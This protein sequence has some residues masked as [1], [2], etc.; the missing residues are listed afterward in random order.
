LLVQ[1]AGGGD[2]DAAG[3]GAD[4]VE[5]DLGLCVER[6]PQLVEDLHLDSP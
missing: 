3:R 5:E 1:V 6:P 2:A 4:D